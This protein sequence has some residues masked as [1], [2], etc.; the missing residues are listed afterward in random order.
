MAN[1]L[2]ITLIGQDRPGLVDA[3]AEA[4]SQ[5]EGNWL[6][7]RLAH[8]GGEFAG[9]VQVEVP[10]EKTKEL[11]QSLATL[12]EEKDLTLVTRED[13][14]PSAS[15]PEGKR[16]GF[17]ILGQ[18]RPGIIRAIS[19]I[20]AKYGVNVEE[21]TS[22]RESAPMSGES[23][24][25]AKAIVLVPA[26]CD[27]STLQGELESLAEELMVDLSSLPDQDPD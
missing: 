21:L 19:H 9:M 10:P 14:G 20:F 6:S 27:T 26:E 15:I 11:L 8:L 7:S 13:E 25:R 1:T 22:A 18:D 16:L 12:A 24:F 5:H 3:M 4:I 17:E 23:L 2:V